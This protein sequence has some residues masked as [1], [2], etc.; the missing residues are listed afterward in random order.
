MT[1]WKTLYLCKLSCGAEAE[2]N[3]I[4]CP[5]LD[6]LNYECDASC[7]LKLPRFTTSNRERTRR[8][9]LHVSLLTV[10]QPYWGITAHIVK[11][12]PKPHENF[13]VWLF[14]QQRWTKS[15]SLAIFGFSY[16]WFLPCVCRRISYT[17]TQ[18][19]PN[20]GISQNCRVKWCADR[21]GTIRQTIL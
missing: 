18:T 14:N 20:L 6:P 12:R 7:P 19:L 9:H 3:Y 15:P 13:P 10:T 1:G 5:S 2:A 8:D 16:S 17:K 4:D 11:R 21:A